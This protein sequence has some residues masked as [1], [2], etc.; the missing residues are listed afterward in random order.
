ML[1]NSEIIQK[2]LIIPIYKNELNIPSLLTS[3]HDLWGELGDDFEVVFVVDGSPDYSYEVLRSHLPNQPYSSQLILLS[4]NFGSF[5]AIR[6]GL[7]VARGKFYAVMAADLQEPP[8]LVVEMFL[9]LQNDCADVVFGQRAGRSDGWLNVFFSKLFWGAF[10]R[11]VI[12]D[13]PSGGVDIFACNGI[14][15]Q[16]ILKLDEANSS[17]VGQLFWVGYRRHFIPYKRRPRKHG[18]SAWKF[19]KKVRY[20]LDSI[21]A[22]SDLPLAL[23]LYLGFT[24]IVLSLLFGFIIF[25]AWLLGA[26][27][28]P[29]YT[30]IMLTL[31]GLG[32]CIIFSQGIIGSYVWRILENTQ[33]RPLVLIAHHDVYS[34]HA[35]PVVSQLE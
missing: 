35:C 7:S 22:F 4:R 16:S 25:F 6:C 26:I 27:S 34:G 1:N 30:P 12:P 31:V 8:E 21:F 17:L 19:R 11:L 29:G 9:C 13:I 33:R 5:S 32:S 14:V 24:G 2:S 3:L 15:K 28:M 10:R 18:K 23:L 20:M